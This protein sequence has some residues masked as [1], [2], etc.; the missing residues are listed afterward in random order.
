[1]SARKRLSSASL[2]AVLGT[3]AGCATLPPAPR[4]PI[5]ADAR[6]LIE[7]LETRWR[8]FSSLRTLADLVV[9]HGGDRHQL[10]GVLLAKAPTSMRFEA[11]SP[12]GQPL[13]LATVHDGRL[14]TYDA[15]T[16]EAYVGPATAEVTA[17][18]LQLPFEPDDL[19]GI[20]AGRPMPPLDVRAASVVPADDVGLSIELVGATNR[21]RIW[22]EPET[23]VVRQFELAGGRAQVRVRYQR[24][25][26]GEVNGFE[27]TTTPPVMSATVRY[28]NPQFDT[29]IASD[30][31]ALTIPKGATIR[32]IR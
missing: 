12:M 6:Q 8:E 11:L 31:F 25:A 19:V 23:A 27:L 30:A 13:L 32:E 22:L 7:R 3:L 17:R 14:T 20:L 28:Q 24:G 18:F 15:T 29:P 4:Q 2:A 5:D 21:R 26:G 10:R 9:Q 16:N 1:M